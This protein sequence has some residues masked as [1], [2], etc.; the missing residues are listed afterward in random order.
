MKGLKFV[1]ADISLHFKQ[2]RSLLNGSRSRIATILK[3]P[4]RWPWF[5]WAKA[6]YYLVDVLTLSQVYA[7]R[8]KLEAL[9]GML[10]FFICHTF[11]LRFS[12]RVWATLFIL[13]EL[14]FWLIFL[15]PNRH[16][17]SPLLSDQHW[18]HMMARVDY[19]ITLLCFKCLNNNSLTYIKHLILLYALS[20][21]L[22]CSLISYYLVHCV[23]LSHRKKNSQRPQPWY[24]LSES[25]RS[26]MHNEDV[27][28]GSN[29]IPIL[30]A[31]QW[32]WMGKFREALSLGRNWLTSETRTQKL[33]WNYSIDAENPT[34]SNYLL[35]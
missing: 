13:L 18:F 22:R 4:L 35:C 34:Y 25:S 2:T 19:N 17:I 11:Y 33:F 5:P 31:A 32:Y 27:P 9:F 12:L 21:T 3:I 26:C 15:I 16:H 10:S 28:L 8:G 29:V 6:Y 24:S 7:C 23:T 14:I 30:V 1:L 20:S